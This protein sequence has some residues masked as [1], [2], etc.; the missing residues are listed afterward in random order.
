MK[1]F[2]SLISLA[3]FSVAHG[4]SQQPTV[5]TD[6]GVVTGGICSNNPSAAYFKSIPFAQP[7]VGNLRFAPPVAFN[8]SYSNGKLN[9]TAAAPACI[10]FGGAGGGVVEAPPY[11]E[12]W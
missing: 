6:A 8:G 9:A 5:K 10:Q 12:D 1:T 4:Q 7:P 2:R 3:F 11:S